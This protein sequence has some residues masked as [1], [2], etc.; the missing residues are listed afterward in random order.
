MCYFHNM[1]MVRAHLVIAGIVQGVFFRA[2]AAEAA[3]K[4]G[5]CGWVK[6]TPDG[7]VE[8]IAEGEESAVNNFIGWCRIGP[9]RARVDSVD[10]RWEEYKNEFDDFSALTRYSSY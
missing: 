2:S 5:V 3:R 6:N 7:T 8:A 1:K 10:V 4:H 9:P